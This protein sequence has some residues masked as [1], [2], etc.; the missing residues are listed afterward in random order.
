M[1]RRNFFKNVGAV[2]LGSAISGLLPRRLLASTETLNKAPMADGAL[3]G[4]TKR[5]LNMCQLKQ[6]EV[7]ALITSS[8][9]DDRYVNAMLTAAGEIGASGAHIAVFPKFNENGD[10][11]SNLNDWH[12]Q[13]YANADLM[14]A[15]NLGNTVGAPGGVTAYGAKVGKHPY[16]TD[17]E[18]INRAGSKT[19]WLDLGYDIPRQKRYFPTAE[20][21]ERCLKG[22]KLLDE[23]RG[24][25]RVVKNN[26]TD[27]R[28][29]NA[30]RPGHAQYG[31]SDV[32]GKW[33]NFGY[34]CVAC[35]PVEESWEGTLVLAPGDIIVEIFPQVLE[36]P[37]KLTFKGGY[38][39][40]IEGGRRAKEF[41]ALLSRFNNKESFGGSHF[42][43]GIHEN[44][45]LANQEDVGHYHHNRI[46][47][48]LIALGMNY[49]HG[50]GGAGAGYAGLGNTTRR[51]PNHSHFSVHGADVFV[52]GR[53]VIE[54]GRVDPVAGGI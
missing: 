43:W 23:N 37:V 31:F 17:M 10:M 51:A 15:T 4:H 3:V 36:E 35:G 39:T 13:T 32:P 11:Q 40:N 28:L 46:G 52:A 47:T 38:V 42:G 5:I 18:F 41:Q 9:Y 21:K 20:R 30:G 7:F 26:G 12:W 49:A 53:K 29:S 2:G 50:L 45:W 14:I 22:A 33:D 8:S 25:I 54:A 34:G 1:E 27:L 16:R 19:R 44:T 48:L 6:G 24:E